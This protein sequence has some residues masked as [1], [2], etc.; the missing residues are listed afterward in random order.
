MYKCKLLFLINIIFSI[1]WVGSVYSQNPGDSISSK[2][3][4]LFTG[5]T[6]T[7]Y[8]ATML[9]LNQLWYKNYSHS[10]FHFF[11]DSGEWLQM[12]KIGHGF[13]SY[14]LSSIFN[15]GF[16]WSGINKRTS[17]I[18]GTGIAFVTI[19]GIEIFDGYSS[20]WG[21]SWSDVT[22]NLSGGL[23]YAGQEL[24]FKKQIFRLKF[25]F[26]T[27]GWAPKRPDAL[28][29]DFTQQVIKDYNGQTYWLSGNLKAITRIKSI[30]AWINIAFGYSG[31]DMLGGKNNLEVNWDYTQGRIPVRYRQYYLSFDIDFTHI[32][33]KSCFVKNFF[34]IINFIKIPFPALVLEKNK[35][36]INPLYF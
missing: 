21:A 24:A 12:D 15:S 16:L 4:Y 29:E 5:A 6:I 22:A 20:K 14:Y 36:K 32:K 17:V 34:K 2:R 7:G 27:S 3:L 26:H 31:D 23:L 9:T 1:F 18:L 30:P 33:V 10:S 8:S 35:L 11:D 28:G 25:S 19:S 13:S